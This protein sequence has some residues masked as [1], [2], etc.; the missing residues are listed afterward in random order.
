MTLVK[1]KS[2]LGKVIVIYEAITER[3]KFSTT[4][5]NNYKVAL[6]FVY[7]FQ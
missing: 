4:K 1:G 7:S 5:E 2:L 6:M 3:V